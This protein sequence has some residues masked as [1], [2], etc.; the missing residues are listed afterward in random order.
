V[1]NPDTDDYKN[2]MQVMQ[3]LIGRQDLTHTIEPDNHPNWWV[4]SSYAIHPDMK[5]H[6][7]YKLHRGK[8]LNIENNLLL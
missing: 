5:S 6:V 3:Y 8:E 1:K 2:L 7:V 4:D